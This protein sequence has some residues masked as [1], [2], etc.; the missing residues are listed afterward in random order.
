[1]ITHI[2]QFPKIVRRYDNRHLTFCYFCHKNTPNL[3]S[4]NWVK[5]I[6]RFIQNK[7]FWFTTNRKPECHL[8]LHPL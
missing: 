4:H 3:S 7:H 6:H 2:F 5:S 8:F 1:M